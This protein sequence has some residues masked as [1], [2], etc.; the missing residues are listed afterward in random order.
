MNSSCEGIY[1]E[2]VR[3]VCWQD[4]L[5]Q[6]NSL[7]PYWLF[8]GQSYKEPIIKEAKI[9]W[10]MSSLER[11]LISYDI[12][13]SYAPTIEKYMIRDFRRRYEGIDFE[14][15]SDD[16]LY[17]LSVMQHHGCPTRLLDCT[18]SP[19]IAGF[20]AVENISF[21]KE[22]ERKAFIFCFNHKWIN[23]S[24]KTN[25]DDNELFDKRFDENTLTDKSLSFALCGVGPS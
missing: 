5:E 17:C 11:A 19:Y 13:L 14:R 15:V 21:E 24:A 18:Y 16:T 23:E 7:L 25:I 2:K 12:P 8:R 1:T 3:E 20:F 9:D 6:S 22:A 10:L 4:Y